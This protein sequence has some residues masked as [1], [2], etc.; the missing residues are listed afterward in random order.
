MPLLLALSGLAPGL[1]LHAPA[2]ARARS[3]CMQIKSPE[4]PGSV[5]DMSAAMAD[6]REQLAA[7]E[8]TSALISAMRGTNI[9]DDDNAASGTTLQVVEMRAGDDSLPTE[10]DPAAL[11]AYFRKRPGAVLTRIGQL[12]LYG[13]AWVAKTLLSALRGELTSGSEG[14]VAAVAGLRDVLVS[15]GPFYIK[16]GQ[17]LS[18]RPDILSP[19]AMVQLQQLCDKAPPFG[20]A[21]AVSQTRPGPVR[22]AFPEASRN[23]PRR[24]RPSSRLSRCSASATSSAWRTS[25]SSSPPSRRSRSPQRRSARCTRRRCARAG[26]RCAVKVQRPAMSRT[27]P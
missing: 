6:M 27:R 4:R 11:S 10:Y 20:R 23:P 18:I 7:D 19:Q 12:A 15:L 21:D 17:A 25:P 5:A 9:N 1:A 24:C 3:P 13:G 14:E 8:R 2:A 16:L 26:T 22:G